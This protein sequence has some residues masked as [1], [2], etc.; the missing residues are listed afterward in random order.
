[1]TP[2]SSSGRPLISVKQANGWS[3]NTETLRPRGSV[4]IRTPQGALIKC[5]V[6]ENGDVDGDSISTVKQRFL[7]VKEIQ[8]SRPDWT[9]PNPYTSSQQS[10]VRS[11][12]FSGRIDALLKQNGPIAL[13]N[14]ED[15]QDPWRSFFANVVDGRLKNARIVWGENH[16]Y[17]GE[18]RWITSSNAPPNQTVVPHGHGIL[19]KPCGVILEG[20]FNKGDLNGQATIIDQH[21]RTFRGETKNGEPHGWGSLWRGKNQNER[22]LHGYFDEGKVK[23]GQKATLYYPGGVMYHGTLYENPV[24]GTFIAHGYGII[25]FPDGLSCKASFCHE[26]YDTTKPIQID[27]PEGTSYKGMFKIVD[28]IPVPHG[29]GRFTLQIHHTLDAEFIEGEFDITKPIQIDY[30]DGTSYKGM[31]EMAGKTPQP[32][33]KGRLILQTQQAFETDFTEGKFDITKPIQINY[34]DGTSY[35]G[36]FRMADRYPEPHGKGSLTLDTQQVLTGNF[37]HGKFKITQATDTPGK[38]LLTFYKTGPEGVT[39]YHITSTNEALDFQHAII[40]YPRGSDKKRYEGACKPS[41]ELHGFGT[42]EK[43]DGTK[44]SCAFFEGSPLQ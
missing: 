10:Q 7:S 44:I 39:I 12:A 21:N 38:E 25:K 33:G 32:H 18:V 5:I 35:K 6:N 8:R 24:D 16:V 28:K 36:T 37:F 42:L 19:R 13:T 14:Y 23:A 22:I 11:L 9:V 43:A 20:V 3:C 1:M 4:E 31:F 27:Y 30:F 2:I 29:H 26:N 41:G 34:P 17:D 40:C 15:S